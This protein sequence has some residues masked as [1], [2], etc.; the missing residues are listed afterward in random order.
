M[1]TLTPNVN[2]NVTTTSSQS[3]QVPAFY[4]NYLD[5]LANQGASAL[6]GATFAGPS[7]LQTQAFAGA[8]GTTTDYQPY[9]DSASSAIGGVNPNAG[10]TAAS[11]YLSAGT[12]AA[13][14]TVGNY[15]NPYISDVTQQIQNLGEQ[16]IANNISPMAT[17]GAVGSGQFG[18]QR[19][20]QVLGQSIANADTGIAAQQAQALESGYGQALT[21]AQQQQALEEQA[22]S[23]AG[24]LASTGVTQGLAQGQ[25]EAGLGSQAQSHALAGLN[26]ESTLGATQQQLN[27]Q[28]SLFP[29]QALSDYGSLLSGTQI[30]TTTVGSS[31]APASTG[32]LQPSTLAAGLSTAGVLGGIGSNVISGLSGLATSGN[33]GTTLGSQIGTAA[34]GLSNYLGLKKGG[35]V[36]IIEGEYRHG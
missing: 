2:P 9:L 8:P 18:S 6:S 12:N 35:K 5:T 17:A 11:P 21:A 32:Q 23:T 31:T 29:F 36:R 34:T 15:M 30:P 25:A 10:I 24:N 19:G 13:Y 20:A 7:S 22:G 28:Q 14:N 3:T 33:N 27:Q 1:G 16:D 26:A 4:Q